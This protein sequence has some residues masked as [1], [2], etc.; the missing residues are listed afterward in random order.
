[1]TIFHICGIE[2]KTVPG[3]R[4]FAGTGETGDGGAATQGPRSSTFSIK[5]TSLKSV[6]PKAPLSLPQVNGLREI[7]PAL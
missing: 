5:M 6:L 2:N 3:P 4:P 7:P 1:M